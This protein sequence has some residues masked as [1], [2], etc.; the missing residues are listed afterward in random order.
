MATG[1]SNLVDIDVD[2]LVHETDKAY[3][4]RI[5]DKKVWI[6]KS[7][8]EWNDEAGTVTMEEETALEKE[9]I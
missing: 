4:F 8:C 2:G 3:L 6:P 5:A 9:L 1:R 7:K